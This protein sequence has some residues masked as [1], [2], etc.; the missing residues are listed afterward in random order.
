MRGEECVWA[1][2]LGKA[3]IGEVVRLGS[4]F[5]HKA[6]LLIPPDFAETKSAASRRRMWRTRLAHRAREQWLERAW[7]DLGLEALYGRN[8]DRNTGEWKAGEPADK[9]LER[10]FPAPGDNTCYTSCLLRIKLLR[11]EKLEPW[12]IFKALRSAIQR[13]G[14]DPNIPWKTREQRRSEAPEDDEGATLAR[15]QEFEKQLAAMVPG[16]PD[17]QW[18]CYFDAW[19]MGPWDPAQPQELR[20]RQDCHAQTTRNQIV[21]RRLVEAEFRALVDAAAKQIPALQGKAEF[22]LYGPPQRAYASFYRD[23]RKRHGLREGGASDW[24]GVR[25]TPKT[26]PRV[27]MDFCWSAGAE[28]ADDESQTQTA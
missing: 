24:R 9:R 25:W 19:K 22:L 6:S 13:R 16:Q 26:G 1:F 23:E 28:T 17:Y 7:K 8:R 3:S 11:G 4:K 18:P 20:N 10:E 12:Q 5:L 21:P 15:M 2:D 27:K 14:Y